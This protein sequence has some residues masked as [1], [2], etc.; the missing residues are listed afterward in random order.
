MT[1]TA[2]LDNSPG[3][4]ARVETLFRRQNLPLTR[5]TLAEATPSS[6]LVTVEA[7]VSG[8]TADLVLKHFRRLVDVKTVT[9]KES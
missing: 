6:Y 8:D 9:V 1:F 2:H 7:P 3:V 4:L 5:L